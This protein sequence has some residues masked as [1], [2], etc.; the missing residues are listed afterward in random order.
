MPTVEAFITLVTGSASGVLAVWLLFA[1]RDNRVK[2]AKIEALQAKIEARDQLRLDEYKVLVPIVLNN[3]AVLAG[4]TEAL[5]ALD[6][7][8]EATAPAGAESRGRTPTGR[9]RRP[10]HD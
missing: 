5:E 9:H 6:V 10:P 3:N 8:V 4:N 1:L 2:D 7:P